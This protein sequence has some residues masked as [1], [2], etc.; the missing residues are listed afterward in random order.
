LTGVPVSQTLSGLSP[1]ITYHFQ[2]AATNAAGTTFGPDQ[3]FTTGAAALPI[4]PSIVGQAA[5]NIGAES[6]TVA[7]SINPNG[8]ATTY[9]VR[10]GTTASYGQ[11]TGPV[12]AGAGTTPQVVSQALAGLTPSTTY[13]FE[14]V[15]TNAGGTTS[16]PDSTFTTAVPGGS[17]AQPPPPA[18]QGV[19]VDVFP[20]AGTVLVNGQPLR[21]G[22][23][24]P[25]GSIIDARHGT[26]VLQSIV[27]G[28][29]QSMQFAGGIFQVLQLPDG[30]I[31]LVLK[32]GD[33]SICKA[34][35]KTTR[36]TASAANATTVRRLWGNGKGKFQTKGRYAAATVR[37][38]IYL[39]ADR[40]D[41]TFT[42]VR[43]GTVSVQDFVLKKTVSIT[44]PKSYLAKGKP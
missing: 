32:G 14:F 2:F 22:Q 28:V 29:V 19:S 5:P 24:I 15:A 25:L 31:Q 3:T 38:T 7:A 21:V 27:N 6:A 26:V 43:E 11:Q 9:F 13:H 41:G 23:Q 20:F 12:S 42:R 10:Y 30:T 35:K 34:S 36:H 1:G 37:G 44:A 33:F 4:A 40:C 8:S 18:V 39:V 17:A 16:G